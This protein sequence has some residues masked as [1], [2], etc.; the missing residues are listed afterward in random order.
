M[1]V[2]SLVSCLFWTKIKSILGSKH[3]YI[4]KQYKQNEVPIITSTHICKQFILENKPSN[5]WLFYAL[6]YD[7]QREENVIPVCNSIGPRRIMGFKSSI[8]CSNIA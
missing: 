4:G 6:S 1:V 3:Y 2:F 7:V 5:L 8:S